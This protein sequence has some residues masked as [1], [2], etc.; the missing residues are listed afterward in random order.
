MKECKLKKAL[1]VVCDLF[2]LAREHRVRREIP[3]FP[4]QCADQA[5]NDI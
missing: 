3:I 5:L 4:V 1:L 2:Y